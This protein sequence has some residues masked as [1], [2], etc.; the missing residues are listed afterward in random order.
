MP[1]IKGSVKI[2]VMLAVFTV[3]SFGFTAS[4]QADMVGVC[5]PDSPAL[6]AASVSLSGNTFTITL[7]NTSPAANGGFLTAVAFNLT[8]GTTVNNFTTTNGNFALFGPAPTGWTGSV[9]PDGTRTHLIS[10]TGND[11]NG[12][13]NPSGGTPTGGTV[14][15]TLTLASLNGNTEASV[16]NSIMIRM[17]GFQN[18]G[19]DKDPL[20]TEAPEPASMLLLGTGLIGIAS[21]FRKRLARKE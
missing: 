19:S 8:P 4:A 20:I 10:A 18:G 6:C 16:F 7:T 3:V 14:T 15:F 17:R 11:Y 9:A 5:A 1:H 2:F 12:G 13:G 21:V